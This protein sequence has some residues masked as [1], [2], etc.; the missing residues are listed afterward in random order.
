MERTLEHNVIAD[1]R[2]RATSFWE[3]IGL[4]V[5][6]ASIVLIA[7]VVIR[8]SQSAAPYGDATSPPVMTTQTTPQFGSGKTGTAR[9]MQGAAQASALLRVYPVVQGDPAVVASHLQQQLGAM[10]DV[11]IAGDR[12][13]RRLIVV[14]PPSV[15]SQLG[16]LASPLGQLGPPLGSTTQ[17]PQPTISPGAAG[18]A[19]SAQNSV[20]PGSGSAAAAGKTAISRH[21][22]RSTGQSRAGNPGPVGQSPAN[23]SVVVQQHVRLWHTPAAQ[24]ETTM[25]RL[26]GSRLRIAPATGPANGAVRVYQI[27]LADGQSVSLVVD[28]QG[29][30]VTVE[31]PPG[32]C[33][34]A[35]QLV[36]MLDNPATSPDQQLGVVF[37]TASR[38]ADIERT[39]RAVRATEARGAV[40]DTHLASPK[41]VDNL[42][43]Q[44][45]T[46]S[47]QGNRGHEEQAAEEQGGPQEP[48]ASRPPTTQAATTG[49]QP[50][51]NNRPPGQAARPGNIGST[52]D[53][54]LPPP[55]S[56]PGL[57]GAIPARQ[58]PGAGQGAGTRQPGGPPA[59][60]QQTPAGEE[61]G[62]LI[63]PVQI[64]MLEGLDVL[65]VRGHPRDV[66]RVVDLINQI[67]QLSVETQPAIELYFLRHVDCEALA[68]LLQQ[69][70]EDVFSTRQGPVSITAL[71]KP[72]AILLI[73]RQESV[74]TVVDL[75]KKLDRPV[76]P[77]TQ[78][79]VFRLRNAAAET[80]RQTLEEFYAE[81]G[82]LGTQ[83][84]V[85]T[86]FR[87]N[88]LLVEASP[89]DMAEV[90]EIIKRLDAGVTEAVHELRVFKL[91]N[92]LAT[93]LAPILQDAITG[94]AYGQRAAGQFGRVGGAVGAAG[95]AAGA[96]AQQERKSVMLRF[97]TVDS[98]GRQMINS[99]ILTD[100]QVTADTRSNSL[101]VSAA[102]ESMPLVE[103]LIRELDELPSAEAQVKVFTLVNGD[104]SSMAEMLQ[105]IF[106]Q[107][108]GTT[109]A[110]GQVA[111]RTGAQEGESTLVPL[112]FAIDVRTNS[113]IASGAAGDLA[114]VEAI[115]LRLDTTDVRN[116][117]SQ[118]YRLRNAPAADVANAL[119]EFLRSERQLQQIAPGLVS[120]FE[121]IEREVVIVP[122]PVSNSLIISATPRFYEEIFKLVEQLDERP[123]MVMIQVLIA[124][125]TLNDTDEFGVEFGLQDSILFD[126]SVAG[127]GD[128]IGTSIPGFLFNSTDPLGNSNDPHA[129]GHAD[130]VG[131]QGLTNFS[132][133][134]LNN[135]LGFGGLVLSASSESVNILI[136]AL[137]ECRR[138]EVI[139][140]P[141]VMTMDNQTAEIV[142]GQDVPTITGTQFTDLGGQINTIQY[143]E[144]GL[145]LTVT[146]RISPDNLVVMEIDAT[147]SEVGPESEGIPVSVSQGQVIRSPRI[148]ITSARTVISAMDGQTVVLGGLIVKSTTRTQRRVPYL[149]NI[150]LVGNLFRYD[151]T[152]ERKAELLIIMTPHIVQNEEDAERIKQIE[153]A[154]MDWCLRDVL[155]LHDADGL[156]SRDSSRMAVPGPVEYVPGD[157]A[158]PTLAPPEQSPE[159]AGQHPGT[160]QEPPQSALPGGGPHS[161]PAAA[162]SQ[163]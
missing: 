22:G 48:A 61:A 30:R 82:G 59:G 28:A 122:E 35:A 137:Q 115:L 153:S 134:R 154:R 93:D 142:V 119:N 27:P 128:L 160:L 92:A 46:Q 77:E 157:N 139:S 87:S 96:S 104:A 56:Q 36:H 148:N 65:V 11:R 126:R 101:L 81:R 42:L 144:V 147:K 6:A 120:A 80:A 44:N 146:P 83:I 43:V 13:T 60:N 14:A 53:A 73:G 52:Q 131:T 37:L 33:E 49:Q 103:A 135:E 121:Q 118:V 12:R 69:L 5:L 159:A 108:T 71:V 136:R 16:V 149:S 17:P 138:L 26:L 38:A 15:H 117:L 68:E 89:R 58:P 64:E 51:G 63:G 91:K 141:Q 155:E 85:S 116:R 47:S 114:I 97:L 132:V 84:R 39:V 41:L 105:T 112:R 9:P 45:T 2:R 113:I 130:V 88:A 98:K 3:R 95:A 57:P 70:Y 8:S 140:R 143:R 19:P 163:P 67:E 25:V 161:P 29:N 123:P 102:P 90:A 151:L 110:T 24:F 78:F 32:A 75:V 156:G 150:P 74:Q 111:V 40:Q 7:T 79:R 107:Q 50:P 100:V 72:N 66:K 145:I 94:T 55:G 86:A 99:G 23:P 127:T 129:L 18:A 106:G 4:G 10:P 34:S 124:E 62:S 158:V 162:G 54:Q 152:A 109:A 1:T 20:L 76:A 21:G 125:V 31:G 133:G